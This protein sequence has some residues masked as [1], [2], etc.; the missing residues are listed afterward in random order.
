M[1]AAARAAAGAAGPAAAAASSSQPIIALMPTGPA[2]AAAVER[3][4]RLNFLNRLPLLRYWSRDILNHLLHT[5]AR[6]F[7]ADVP[8]MLRK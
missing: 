2:T 5:E 8:K 6:K 1:A 4:P 3:R 7:N